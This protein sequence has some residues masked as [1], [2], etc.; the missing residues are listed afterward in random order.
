MRK[1]QWMTIGEVANWANVQT[2]TLRYYESIGILP[3]PDRVNGRRRYKPEILQLLAVIELAKAADFS[4]DEIRTLLYG[5]DHDTPLS[6]RW[7]L[8]AREKLA[9]VNAIIEAAR[10][11]KRLL[12]EGLQNE[13]L[14][15][16]LDALKALQKSDE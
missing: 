6:E 1:Q 9:E 13:Y 10:R 5:F 3:P 11:K 7:K 16:E 2:S 15:F 8:L 4:L 14:R 12:E